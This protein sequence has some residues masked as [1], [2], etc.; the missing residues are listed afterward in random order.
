MPLETNEPK[1][2]SLH[3]LRA[4]LDA[5]DREGEAVAAA[6]VSMALA[7]VEAGLEAAVR[8]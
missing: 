1:H 5:L 7:R 6:H 8:T 3:W 2:T 4:A